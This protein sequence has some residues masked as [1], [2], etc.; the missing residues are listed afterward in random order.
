M[1]FSTKSTIFA[2][3]LNENIHGTESTQVSVGSISHPGF[4]CGSSWH[5]RFFLDSEGA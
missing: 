2:K 3:T 4:D 5:H 1:V